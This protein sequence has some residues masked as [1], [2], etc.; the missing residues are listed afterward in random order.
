MRVKKNKKYRIK[1]KSEWFKNKYGS[2][3]PFIT[4][5]DT[6]Y[7]V[8]GDSWKNR[9]YVPAVL[10]FMIRQVADD[11]VHLG[12]KDKAYYGKIF[13]TNENFGIGE[14]VFKTE[15]EEI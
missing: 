2:E 7:E 8:F 13:T 10:A 3:T 11:V 5:E 12:E 15:L 6:D 4:I 14:L 1:T 9:K